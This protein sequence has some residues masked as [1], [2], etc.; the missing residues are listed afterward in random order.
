MRALS[1]SFGSARA[2]WV[3][4]ER[5]LPDVG[6]R[7]H[8]LVAERGKPTWSTVLPRTS[9]RR[10]VLVGAEASPGGH[11]GTLRH[12]C[13]EM[14]TGDGAPVSVRPGSCFRLP[15]GLMPS[16]AAR[17]CWAEPATMLI[18]PVHHST[19]WPGVPGPSES[20][21]F[22]GEGL[23]GH[24]LGLGAHRPRL[25]LLLHRFCGQS[26]EPCIF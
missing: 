18:L 11:V 25:L 16:E 4:G 6:T 20:G 19:M 23:R 2:P 9:C 12:P 14:H 8:S 1:A 21:P 3:P 7:G 10:G 22:R 26:Q 15:L 13:R 17:S 24:S 5:P